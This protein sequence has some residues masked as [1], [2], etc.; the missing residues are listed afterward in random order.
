MLLHSF[1]AGSF[2][3]NC[4]VL[5]T[6]SGQACVIVDP[7]QDAA[8]PLHDIVTR[9][10]LEPEAVLLT[11][12]HMD[13]TWDV[14]PVCRRYG[15]PAYIHP[16]DRFMLDAPAR[17]LPET[18]PQHVLAG[19]PNAEPASVLPLGADQ[20]PL[21]LAG[22]SIVARHTA[23]HTPGSVVLECTV[24]D[25]LLFTGDALLA[26]TLGRTDGPGGSEPVLRDALA[27]I[28]APLDGSTV[29]LTGH[30]RRTTLA[31]ERRLHPFLGG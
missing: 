3:T 10:R 2:G 27:R 7:G 11:H 5:A 6:A 31:E 30:G 25:T 9:Y 13:H 18:F 17:G 12:G 1:P 22:L 24:D 8:E 28:C 26:G 21:R 20:R 29:L 4:Y 23:G 14:L 19:H 16:D 15:V